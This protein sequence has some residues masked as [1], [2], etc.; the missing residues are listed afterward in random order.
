MRTR[1]H[2]LKIQVGG[3]LQIST[4]QRLC[5]FC[6]MKAIE[7]ERHVALECP[8]YAHIKECFE[9]LIIGCHT[10]EDLLHKTD[11]TPAALGMFFAKIIEW[12]RTLLETE[13]IERAAIPPERE[14]VTSHDG[15]MGHF[16]PQRT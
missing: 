10:F 9:Q 4:P 1:S 7:D 3:W 11:P 13:P 14:N 2:M 8:A 15:P 12:H 6:P 16:G 5:K